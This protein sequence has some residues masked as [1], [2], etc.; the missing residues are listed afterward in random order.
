M[1][2]HIAWAALAVLVTAPAYAGEQPREPDS[3][4][5]QA[6][7]DDI[8]VVTIENR[9]SVFLVADGKVLLSETNFERN[10][11]TLQGHIA[12]VTDAPVRLIVNTHWHGDHIGG[13]KFFHELGATT[14]AHENTRIRMSVEQVNPV[15]N[16]VQLPAQAPEFL[17]M[18]TVREG[19]VIHWGDETVEVVHYPTAHTDS[20]LVMYFRNA[21]VIFAGGMLEYST[22]AGV[23]N[24]DGFMAAL[25]QI[26]ARAD[27]NTKVIPWQGPVVGRAELQEWRD[28][29]QH[30][31]TA[32]GAMIAEGK[33]ID[34]IIAAN[35]SAQYDAKWGGGRTPER[36][37]RDM[38]YVLTND[39]RD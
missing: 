8:H 23:Y 4:R 7:T 25:D 36:F 27:E 31:T 29:I 35:P 38:H 24:P 15:T 5:I 2:R 26:I 12:S 21:N 1:K 28:I 6:V 37:A 32:V 9:N 3:G 33:T 11:E 13:N 18:I 22:Y 10:A 39:T 30:M 16:Q 19:A 14:M 20:D 34:E 17:P